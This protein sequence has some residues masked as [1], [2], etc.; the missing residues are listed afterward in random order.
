MTFVG[1]VA[2]KNE[3]R[4]TVSHTITMA[5]K[6]SETNIK[7]VSGDHREVCLK[8]AEKTGIINPAD[9]DL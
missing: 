2:F 1:Y 3:I 7:M 8:V 5:V 9:L 6:K 4:K